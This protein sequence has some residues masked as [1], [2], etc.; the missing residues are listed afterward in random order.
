MINRGKYLQAL[1]HSMGNGFVKI[2]TGIR[3][4]GKSYLLNTIFYDYL[5]SKGI[6]DGHIVRFAFDSAHDLAKMGENPLQLAKEK[7]LA[8][9]VKFMT[10]IQNQIHDKGTYY[11]LL[12]EVQEL[13]A[14]ETVLN[15]CLRQDNLDVFVTGS[16]A[17]FLSKDIATEFAGRG[18]QIH[19]QP[20]SFSEFMSQYKGDKYDGLMEYMLYGG[21]PLVVLEQDVQKK[22]ILLDSLFQEIYF[23]DIQQRNKLRHVEDLQDILDVLS[24]SVGS[25][26]NAE[27]IANTLRSN[28][29]SSISNP[30]VSKYVGYLEDTFLVSSCS[31][32][33]VKGRKYIGSS[34][35]YYFYDMGLR[36]AR[37]NFRQFEQ[38]HIMENIIYNELLYRG[39]NVDVGVV[40]IYGKNSAGANVRKKVEVDFVCN[41]GMG[42]LYLQSAFSISDEE[43]RQQEIR[44]YR[45]IAD[46]FKKVIITKDMV[47]AYYDNDGILT[48]NIFDFILNRDSLDF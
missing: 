3:R 47:P 22:R 48:I 27:K 44:P 20:L 7:R 2:I 38:T 37:L 14:F 5:L 9:P 31:Q 17:K 35:K 42:R 18:D 8:D 12:D 23:R 33:D 4:C 34:K 32:Y 43:K 29:K 13:A 15:S 39:Y 1:I 46:S 19:M 30:T 45:H 21:L 41:N 36:N 25:F 16:N 40:E 11:L 26:S 28:K 10:F 6:D 24:S